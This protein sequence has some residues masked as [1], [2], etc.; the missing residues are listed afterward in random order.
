MML[1][2]QELNRVC[3]LTWKLAMD[4]FVNIEKSLDLIQISWTMTIVKVSL[5]TD[6]KMDLLFKHTVADRRMQKQRYILIGT[7]C[8]LS[9]LCIHSRIGSTYTNLSK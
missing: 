5:E 3:I 8:T 9:L 6:V 4:C 1:V 2:A 7:A